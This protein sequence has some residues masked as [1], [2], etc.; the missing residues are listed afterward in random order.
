MRGLCSG[1]DA[2]SGSVVTPIAKARDESIRAV[3]AANVRSTELELLRRRKPRFALIA[4]GH[5]RIQCFTC[6]RL[7][8]HWIMSE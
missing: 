2:A 1:V 7:A 4:Q 6:S 3:F 5:G 8:I